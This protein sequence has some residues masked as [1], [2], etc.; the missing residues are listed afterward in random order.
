MLQ[1]ALAPCDSLPAQQSS[2]KLSMEQQE[3]QLHVLSATVRPKS[4]ASLMSSPV[5]GR[6]QPFQTR[7]LQGDALQQL[8][9]HDREQVRPLH[10]G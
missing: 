3:R 7:S 9:E 2:A 1:Q 6:R 5:P 4:V 8:L 10:N